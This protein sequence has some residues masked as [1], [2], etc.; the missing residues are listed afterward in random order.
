MSRGLRSG[1]VS[2]VLCLVCAA[3]A[4]DPLDIECPDLAVGDLV[5]T[6][7]RGAQSGDDVYEQW[8]ELFNAS[9]RNI[10]MRG[11]FI[12]FLEL[13]GGSDQTI[14]V[15]D[16]LTVAAGQYVTLGRQ[17]RAPLPEYIDY[18]YR[19]DVLNDSHEPRKMFDT[20]A[21]QVFG[22][23]RDLFVDQ[24]VYRDLPSKGTL[25]VD[26]AIDP[27]DPNANDDDGAWCVDE[28]EDADSET[29]GIRGTPQEKN[30]TCM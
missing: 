8:F 28:T 6:E 5:V 7:L 12:R 3:C 15:R 1:L 27:P 18:G 17:P 9:G 2:V 13:D 20:A 29:D 14:L 11:V 4:R 24:A 22:C 21:V 25:I 19:D 26:G 23:N 16:P 10:P 30:R